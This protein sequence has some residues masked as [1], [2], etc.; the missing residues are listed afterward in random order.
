MNWTLFY[1]FLIII[2]LLNTVAAVF[3]VFRERRDIA[4]T[5][6]WL[7]VLNLL[8]VIGFLFYAFF[9][10]KLTHRQL[11]KIQRQ[12]PVELTDA[13]AL[14]QSSL[15]SYSAGDT[16]EESSVKNMIRLFQNID[17]SF[18]TLNNKTELFIDGPKL[19]KNMQQEILN[20]QHVVYVEFYTF[21][22][23]LIG[24]EILS[25]L[26]EK[27][28]EGVTVRVLYDSWGSM[29]TKRDF[30]EP[31]REAGGFAEPFLGIHSNWRDFRLNFRNHR[32]IVAIDGWTGY[33]GGFNIGDQ[34]VDRSK[35]FGHWRDTHMK[36]TGDAALALQQHFVADWNATVPENE[37]DR[38]MTHFPKA[39][40]V[41]VGN[42]MMQIVVS[43]PDSDL[44][45]IK[46]G[47]LR[48]INSARKRLYIQTPYLIPDDSV[49][50]ALRSV[51][52]SGVD[53]R[54]MVPHMP[55]HPFVYRATQ[56]Y[57]RILAEDGAKI[58]FYQDGFIH[59]KV[60][61]IDDAISSVGSANLDFRS[62]KL[63]FEANA[64]VYDFKVAKELRDIF[65]A[66]IEKSQLISAE[67][68]E[69]MSLW[70]RFKQAFSRLLAPIL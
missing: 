25:T 57:A 35:K 62:F 45:Q 34:Y 50:N 60:V 2:I 54:I 46:M 3:T 67:D 61:M 40:D 23:D 43:G 6:A 22:N 31:L 21:Y 24:K 36:V 69:N 1:S 39:N 48:M 30:F 10:R 70:L 14:Q 4:A 9:G 41:A 15:P 13:L 29:G 27:A 42:T 68:F 55:D 18:V 58:Y 37:L 12:P 19:F 38:K 52:L 33:I 11:H 49:L 63:N 17:Q 59:A 56:Y 8:P 20:A 7:L 26:V 28:Q 44:E 66:D 65:D 64:F 51:I 5:W 32:K 47:Y 53:V 16:H